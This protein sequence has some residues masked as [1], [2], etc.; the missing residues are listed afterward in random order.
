MSSKTLP[1]VSAGNGWRWKAPEE[2]IR[3]GD[4]LLAWDNNQKSPAFHRL[5]YKFEGKS[6][7]EVG[8]F[9]RTRKSQPAPARKKDPAADDD[10]FNA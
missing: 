6:P 1:K 10:P 5:P 8:F 2:P 3:E 7:K 4:M 9:V